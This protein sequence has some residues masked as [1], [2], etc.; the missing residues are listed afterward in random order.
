MLHRS[1]RQR[2]EADKV[3]G[4]SSGQ[5]WIPGAGAAVPGQRRVDDN[6]REAPQTWDGGDESAPPRERSIDDSGLLGL[7]RPVA[8]ARPQP[9]SRRRDLGHSTRREEP[10]ASHEQLGEDDYWSYLRGERE[11][12]EPPRG[13]ADDRPEPARED[14]GAWRS[15]ARHEPA[16]PAWREPT[17][18]ASPARPESRLGPESRRP[19]GP[20]RPPEDPAGASAEPAREPAVEGEPPNQRSGRRGKG[21]GFLGRRRGEPAESSPV[22]D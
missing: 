9:R 4:M 12:S 21:W 22:S 1:C 8:D 11:L 3:A 20:G 10:V 17:V 6:D 5:S 13:G 15:D 2:R 19:A 18:P 7:R 16:V 14:T